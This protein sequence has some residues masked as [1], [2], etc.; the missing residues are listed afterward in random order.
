M[1]PSPYSPTTDSP[2]W[3]APAAS[4]PIDAR[5]AVPGSK[6]LTNRE[7]VLAALGDSPS[8]LVAPLD[9]RDTRLMVAGLEALG[10]RCEHGVDAAGTP[11]ITVTPIR[12]AEDDGTR[13]TD[14]PGAPDRTIDCG[15]AGTVMR[16]LPVVATLVAGRTRFIGDAA[17]ERRPM[18][19]M[20]DAVRALGVTVVDD[21]GHPATGLP[22]T[23]VS[24][25]IP[26][27]GVI[28]IDASA[29]SQFV[30]ALLLTAP[31][32]REGVTLRHRGATLP[33]LPHIDMTVR[34]LRERRVQVDVDDAAAEAPVWR[35]HAGTIA[36]QETVI[37]P[38]LS[39]AEPFLLA[40][41]IAG[42]R[43]RIPRWPERT[44]QVG[45]E[46]RHLLPRLGADIAH[47]ADGVLECTVT[48]GLVAGGR[49]PALQLDLHAAGE[50]APN[51]VAILA[52]ADGTSEVRGIGHLR[53]HETDRLAALGAE[54][55]RVGAGV[56]ELPDGLR[57]HGLGSAQAAMGA[58]PVEW[59]AYADH[60][61]ATSGALM[62]LAS[63]HTLRGTP[64]PA[65][66]VDDI[67]CTD[68]TMPEF[69]ELWL[70]M[71]GTRGD[72]VRIEPGDRDA[73]HPQRAVSGTSR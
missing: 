27:G 59:R 36:G 21:A 14:G 43:V 45:D 20:L 53:G 15:L 68:K 47:L 35:V 71:L 34:C 44:T 1:T 10:A 9:A 58:G 37:E 70:A 4:G 25:G 2:A 48:R 73:R 51:L 66:T 40:A 30:S 8:T 16:F 12:R 41:L 19:A 50:L 56:D 38:D 63:G 61:M 55:R 49:I 54:L 23:V 18:G 65:V 22:F 64:V 32:F 57:I 7:L 60:R 3:T 11:T 39:N 52:L 33:S 42:G 62:G 28:D 24:D 17:A 5:V 6:S 46:L 69:A 31:R 13:P 72:T 67:A 29:S 26:E